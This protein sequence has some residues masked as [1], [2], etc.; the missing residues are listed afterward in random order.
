[1]PE[2]AAAKAASRP[3]AVVDGAAQDPGIVSCGSLR[4]AGFRVIGI[5]SLALPLGLRSRSCDALRWVDPDDGAAAGRL[6]LLRHWRPDV[7]LPVGNRGMRF[8]VGH[9]QELE[10]LTALLIPS[11]DGHRQAWN[12]RLCQLSCQQLGIAVPAVFSPDQAREHLLACPDRPLVVKPC[13]DAGAALGQW[14]LQRPDELSE[15]LER[16]RSGF[17]GPGLEPLIQEWVPGPATAMRSLLLGF[18]HHGG[19][20]DAVAIRKRRQWP[21][22]GGVTAS[23]RLCD[24]REIEELLAA[25]LPFFRH[26]RWR[27]PAE[28]EF[29]REAGTNRPMLIEINPRLPAWLRYAVHCGFDLPQALAREALAARASACGAAATDGRSPAPGGLMSAPPRRWPQREG[30][31]SAAGFSPRRQGYVQPEAFLRSCLAEWREDPAAACRHWQEPL[32]DLWAAR[33]LLMVQATDPLP[34]L[35]RWLG[36]RWQPQHWQPQSNGGGLGSALP[37]GN[38]H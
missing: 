1:M 13:W 36:Q 4:R 9:R 35:G 21:R 15:A 32:R 2:P 27:G 30:Q 19:L 28:V 11:E 10:A 3:L 38:G 33:D 29:K 20:I 23:A 8:A 18:D 17:G 14:R 24:D 26:Y 6:A 25:V 16:C 34:L 22:Q 37:Q 5:D 7:Y 12:K 31:R